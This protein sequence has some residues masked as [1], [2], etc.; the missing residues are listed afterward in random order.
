MDGLTVAE[1]RI[2][3]HAVADNVLEGWQPK[4]AD[5]AAL[6]DVVRG[7]TTTKDY[8]KSVREGLAGQEKTE[9]T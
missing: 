5:I 3:I 7:K 4:R 8:I 2:V 6:I 1:R 9:R